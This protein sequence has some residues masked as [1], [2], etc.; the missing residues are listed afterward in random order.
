MGFRV[1]LC[2]WVDFLF[3]LQKQKI[4][5]TLNIWTTTKALFL[6]NFCSARRFR[7]TWTRLMYKYTY[8]FQTERKRWENL[9][10]KRVFLFGLLFF[11]FILFGYIWDITKKNLMN[12]DTNQSNFD[13]FFEFFFLGMQWLV[14][15]TW[16]YKLKITKTIITTTSASSKFSFY[17]EVIHDIHSNHLR[18]TTIGDIDSI[19]ARIRNQ[20]T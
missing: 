9:T 7:Q 11:F 19:S 18:I 13:T 4:H 12:F 8:I 17:V 16:A 6:S 2:V 15:L 5:W 14:S 20:L 1:R 10:S 3:P